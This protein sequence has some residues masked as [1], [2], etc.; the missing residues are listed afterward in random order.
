M[1]HE[2]MAYLINKEA[3]VEISRQIRL[4]G[5][6]G[7]ILID[8]IDMNKEFHK[9]E[10]VNILKEETNRDREPV[11]VYGMT[12]LG[13]VEMTRKR[14]THRLLQNYYDICPICKGTG[15]VSSVKSIIQKIYRDLLRLDGAGKGNNLVIYCHPDVADVL[16][17]QEEKELMKE[18][19]H[20][21]IKIEINSH[22][23][24]EVYSILSDD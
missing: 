6:G 16:D 3:A 10:I 1:P 5:I 22:P 20:K 13:L 23:N 7:M 24:R 8:F 17:K 11:V 18:N 19:F 4:R 15:Y 2:E 14:T 12:S 21:N 9:R